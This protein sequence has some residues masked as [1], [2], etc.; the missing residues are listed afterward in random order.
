MAA[1]LQQ[2]LAELER[3]VHDELRVVSYKWLSRAFSLP[4]DVAKQVLYKFAESHKGRVEATYLAAGWTKE[5]PRSHALQLTSSGKLEECKAAMAEVTSVH[6]YSVQQALPKDAAALW[7]A[8]FIQAEELFNKA[9][10]VDNCLWDNRFSGVA[11]SEARPAHAAG[12]AAAGSAQANPASDVT[13][14][15]PAMQAELGEKQV[16]V[17]LQQPT[18]VNPEANGSKDGAE[19]NAARPSAKPAAPQGRK[20]PQ[21]TT[22][23]GGA[24]LAS[25]WGKQ[26]PSR[27]AAAANADTAAGQPGEAQEHDHPRR[28]LQPVNSDRAFDTDVAVLSGKPPVSAKVLISSPSSGPA[29]DEGEHMAE[30]AVS[31]QDNVSPPD[32]LQEVNVQASGQ[33]EAKVADATGAF[34]RRKVLQTVMDER[35][36]EVTRIVWEGEDGEECH[37]SP[38]SSPPEPLRGPPSL[39]P[40]QDASAAKP[41]AKPAVAGKVMPKGA[42]KSG[43]AAQKGNIMN[44]FKKG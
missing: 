5:E 40:S 39:K 27:A 24:S 3:L 32:V 29:V 14:P 19:H 10:R 6:V 2:L 38:K 42:T 44:F 41:L 30:P 15:A 26:L 35:G 20:R 36:R 11:S 13:K 12:T 9:R 17:A 25:L 33:S 31:S 23:G 1:N 4:S 37:T 34:K 43:K 28:A 22:N 7:S 8:E 21:G 16:P 18:D